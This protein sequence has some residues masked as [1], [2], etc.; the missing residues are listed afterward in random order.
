MVDLGRCFLCRCVRWA[1]LGRDP[2]LGQTSAAAWE[3]G[4]V[5]IENV[6]YAD[7]LLEISTLGWCGFGFFPDAYCWCAGELA[8]LK[9]LNRS[10]VLR[11]IK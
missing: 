9:P 8:R 5:A 11:I 10:N 2:L 1:E 7:R 6:T 3:E 4:A